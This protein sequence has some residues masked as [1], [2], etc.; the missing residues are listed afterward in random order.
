MTIPVESV[1]VLGKKLWTDA[2][3][4][5]D[6]G[7]AERPWFRMRTLKQ[8]Y[9]RFSIFLPTDQLD[10]EYV[11]WETMLACL[12]EVDEQEDVSIFIAVLM[13]VRIG[14]NT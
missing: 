10:R 1:A 9:E 12:A 14:K 11:I 8:N 4:W 6:V 2:V 7:C 3:M 5:C 13:N